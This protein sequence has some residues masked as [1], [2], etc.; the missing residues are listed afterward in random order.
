MLASGVARH[1]DDFQIVTAT[2][3]L[4]RAVPLQ[5]QFARP[6]MHRFLLCHSLMHLLHKASD[7]WVRLYN[8]VVVEEEEKEKEAHVVPCQELTSD[9][10]MMRVTPSASRHAWVR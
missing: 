2:R 4:P 3:E 7:T 10:W 1:R 6:A 9:E 8:E 5:L